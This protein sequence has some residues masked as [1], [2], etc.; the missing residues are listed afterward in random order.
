MNTIARYATGP[1]LVD[2]AAA[3][4]LDRLVELQQAS[5]DN[6]ELCLT[7]GRIANRIYE[8]VIEQLDESDLD[9]RRLELWWGDENFVP[10]EDPKRHAGHTLAILARQLPLTPALTHP[11][12][13]ADG[14]V[15][16]DAAAASYAKELGETEF[17]ICLLGLGEEGHVASIFPGHDSFEATAATVV[18][19]N[20]APKP[21]GARITL[22]VPTL[23]RSREVWFLVSG[24]S[25]AS[26]VARALAEDPSIPGGVV[27][28]T[29]STLWLLDRAAAAAVPYHDCSF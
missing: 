29:E 3:R 6:V 18:G 2:G 7:G 20:G 15:D 25:K 13:A 21:P 19:V 24:E 12:P 26:A 4:L 16:A 14:V 10:T 23:Q 5:E 22:T 27:R 8:G 9:P 28:G 1:D 17:D 11:M